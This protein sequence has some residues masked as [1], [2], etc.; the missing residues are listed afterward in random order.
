MWRGFQLFICNTETSELTARGGMR[1]S[2][3][4]LELLNN[5]LK[6]LPF[7][8]L[9]RNWMHFN[10]PFALCWTKT[11]PIPIP[12][13]SMIIETPPFPSNS[14][15]SV[16]NSFL[17]L[18]RNHRKPLKSRSWSRHCCQSFDFHMFFVSTRCFLEVVRFTP[19]LQPYFWS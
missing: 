8:F 9:K 17:H 5:E 11:Q 12:Q 2:G 16:S 3:C 10:R 19:L 15:N 1:V 13:A 18:Q 4:M 7:K 14:V 6:T